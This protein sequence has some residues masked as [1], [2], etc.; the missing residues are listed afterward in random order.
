MFGYKYNNPLGAKLQKI[1]EAKS[2]LLLN[3]LFP[4][5]KRK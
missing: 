4:T 3:P 1:F 2:K 5:L